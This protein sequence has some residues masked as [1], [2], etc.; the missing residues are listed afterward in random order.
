MSTATAV[1]VALAAMLGTGLYAAF[2]PAAAAAGPWLPLAVLLAAVV[3]LCNVSSIADLTAARPG[4]GGLVPTDL[5]PAAGRLAGI[6]RL[7]ARG[8][9]A[10]A[11]AGVFGAY[12]LPSQPVP[13]AIVA[14]LVVIGLNVAG[15]RISVTACRAL[16]A[17]AVVILALVTVVGAFPPGPAGPSAALESAAA[18][19]APAEL[20]A[21]TLQAAVPGSVFGVLTAA[22]FVFF[23]FAGTSR[24]AELGGS[25]RDPLR[26]VRRASTIAVLIAGVIF[27]AV[28]GALLNGL[29]VDRLSTSPIPLASLIDSGSSPALG[30]L[31]RVG[32]AV[33][34]G[35]ALLAVL[36]R[37]SETASRMARDGDLPRL[38][39]RT[40]SR[41]TPWVADLAG[42]VLVVGVTV[43]V[44][45]VTALA[46]S[47]CA[48][49]V[50]Y[51][52]LH[53]AALR[54]RGRSRR[55]L[56]VAAAGGLLCLAL[57]LS[58]PTWALSSTAVLLVGGW[59]LSTLLART[60]GARGDDELPRSGD[61]GEQAA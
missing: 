5:P 22:A 8:A 59:L 25:L 18:A 60:A 19:G 46:I 28:S 13:V 52:L 10:V 34:T 50:H 55:T 42:G 3:A 39:A 21:A 47:A 48:V 53:G 9:A 7:V 38:L 6:A 56:V 4:G 32:A 37:G 26:T 35:S 44:G 54:L 15:V 29:G 49:L 33:A 2:A 41:G 24:V 30:V 61:T 43:L 31:V 40:G 20:P 45:P 23:A 57:A 36:S 17:G 16:V 51:A 58:L 11:A 1:V 14:V 27:L 12:V